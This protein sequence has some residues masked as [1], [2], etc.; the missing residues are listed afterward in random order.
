MST[1]SAPVALITGASSGIGAT[2][3]R[4]LARRGYEL[5]LVARRADKLNEL[6][7]DLPVHC[8]IVL[9]D[10]AA[11][12]GVAAVAGVIRNC[13]RLELLVN[14]AGFGT[15]GRFWE[16]EAAGQDAMHR[17]H[18]LAV[19]NLTRAALEGMT[20]RNRGG[21]INVASVAAFSIN[22]GNVSYCATKTWMNSF[23][24]GLALELKGVNSQVKVQTLCPGFT[25]TE[26][27]DT[28]GVDRRG[29]PDWLWMKADFV[30]ETSLRGLDRGKVIVVPGWIY[31][32]IVAFLAPMPFAIRRHLRRPFRDRRV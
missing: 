25:I 2:F 17:V 21:V 20:A 13:T 18:V 10:L 28:L 32:T 9:A 5:I 23:T 16:T 31:Q 12:D 6:A 3:A 27:H 14:N 1:T 22:E 11:D 4:H 19:V 8:E 30:V 26:F 7:R 24:E 29:I 15:L